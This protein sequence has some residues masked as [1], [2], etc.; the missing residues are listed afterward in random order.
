MEWSEEMKAELLRFM[1]EYG[2]EPRITT[3]LLNRR[4]GLS[5]SADEVQTYY[6]NCLKIR[7]KDRDRDPEA[8]S[9]RSDEKNGK[10]VTI[11]FS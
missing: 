3:K 4:F 11:W 2:W 1:D 9:D 8:A 6:W 10:I 7:A 5:L